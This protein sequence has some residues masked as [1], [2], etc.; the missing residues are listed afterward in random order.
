[1]PKN[2]PIP[3]YIF[4]MIHFKN[5][6]YVLQNGMCHQEHPKA[7][8]E[9]INIGN[10]TLIKDRNDYNIKINPPGGKLGEYVP[11]YFAGHS[12]ML[13]QIKTGYGVTHIPQEDIIFV[14]CDISD[15]ISTCDEWCFTDGHAKNAM[16]S[17]YNDLED[18]THIDWEAVNSTIWKNTENDYDK[19][20]KKQAEFLVKHYVPVSCIKYIIVKSEKRKS[21]VEEIITKLNLSI[22][23]KIDINNK[24]YY[25]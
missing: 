20:R 22:P 7:D 13:Y 16:S 3:I 2:P 19:Q 5:I 9:Y 6:E 24:L 15:V 18:L 4:R 14:C 25:L 1:M 17:F 8:P 12:P 23:V 21:E 10:P 11:F